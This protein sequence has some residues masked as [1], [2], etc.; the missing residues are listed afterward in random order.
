MGN[1]VSP[2]KS[3]WSPYEVIVHIATIANLRLALGG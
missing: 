3:R 2:F 1:G